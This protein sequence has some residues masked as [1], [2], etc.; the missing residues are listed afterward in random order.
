MSRITS[1]T[2]IQAPLVV[3]AGAQTFIVG[4]MNTGQLLLCLKSLLAV[5][6][7]IDGTTGGLTMHQL[8]AQCPLEIIDIL[9]CALERSPA[10]VKGLDLLETIDLADALFEQNRNFL[11]GQVGPRLSLLAL[12][13]KT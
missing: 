4:R 10:F 6:A 7:V 3:E 11:L 5:N 12:K 2:I 13:M 9:S 1:S 8:A